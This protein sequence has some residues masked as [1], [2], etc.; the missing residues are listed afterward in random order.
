MEKTL[1]SMEEGEGEKMKEE[2]CWGSEEVPQ[3]ALSGPENEGVACC[4]G[5]RSRGVGVENEGVAC[6]WG[7]RS[8]GV[9]V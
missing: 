4:W 3:S 1:K 6:C 9:G 2:G 7:Q 8:R 5:Q